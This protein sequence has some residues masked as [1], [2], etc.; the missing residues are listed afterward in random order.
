MRGWKPVLITDA[1]S[2]IGRASAQSLARRGWR[3]SAGARR[4]EAMN[5]VAWVA[6]E[7]GAAGR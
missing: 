6:A 2:G 4:P 1:S 5:G 7:H 3:V